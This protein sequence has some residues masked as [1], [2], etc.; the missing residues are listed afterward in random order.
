MKINSITTVQPISYSKV[1][2]KNINFEAWNINGRHILKAD[3]LEM[4]V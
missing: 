3:A 1:K 2:Q 4:K